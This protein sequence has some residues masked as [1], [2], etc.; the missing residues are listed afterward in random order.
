[1]PVDIEKWCAEP[2]PEGLKQEQVN[3]SRYSQRELCRNILMDQTAFVKM[4]T[5]LSMR[6]CGI[7]ARSTLQ[8][9]LQEMRIGYP[10]R[11]SL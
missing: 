6:R 3:S 1:M 7:L 4:Q 10:G 5:W 9:L 11:C 2:L 8:I